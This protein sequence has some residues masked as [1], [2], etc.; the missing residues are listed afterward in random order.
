MATVL[1]FPLILSFAS[2]THK[3][4][5]Q[6]IVAPRKVAIDLRVVFGAKKA[7][8]MMGL[9]QRLVQLFLIGSLAEAKIY[10]I[11]GA[12]DQLEVLKSRSLNRNPPA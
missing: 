2:T 5:G 7:Y 10:A 8:V 11:E 6:T 12:K 3:I 1:Q 9:V 4:Q